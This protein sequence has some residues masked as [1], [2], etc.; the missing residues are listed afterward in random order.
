[1]YRSYAV[2]VWTT[3]EHEMSETR[4]TVNA[5]IYQAISGLVGDIASG[6]EEKTRSFSQK[7]SRHEFFVKKIKKYHAAAGEAAFRSG[8]RPKPARPC[9][10]YHLCLDWI[11][12]GNDTISLIRR[13]YTVLTVL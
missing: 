7:N 9:N 4:E 5:D 8:T 11:G 10:S 3:K 13:G 2:G 1:M 12:Y 6:R